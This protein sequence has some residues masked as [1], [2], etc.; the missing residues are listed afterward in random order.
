[1]K[2][3]I[4]A[5]IAVIVFAFMV[6]LI[7][8]YLSPDDLRG[9]DISLKSKESSNLACKRVDAIVAVSGGDTDARTDEAVK[10]YKN[11]WSNLLIFS[12]AAADKTGPS[13]AKAMRKHA[14]KK[15]VPDSAIVIEE[16]S[17]TTQ[18]NARLS[19]N[20]FSE[21]KISRIILVTSAYHQR[22]AGIEFRLAAGGNVEVINHPVAQDKQWSNWWWI[23][24]NGW[25]LAM[26]EII[27][28]IATYAGASR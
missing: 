26:S 22:R 27:K 20:V 4:K 18:E 3:M 23:S 10:L 13:N 5:I 25:W 19:R 9:C 28:I 2:F 12:G 1:M 17:N 8:T 11:G 16:N 7:G 6:L 21:R 15:G 14:L 24:P